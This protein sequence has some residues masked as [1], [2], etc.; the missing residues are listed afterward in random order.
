[1][2][3]CVCACLCCTVRHN[4]LSDLKNCNTSSF[5]LMFFAAAIR[6]TSTYLH[7]ISQCSPFFV[8]FFSAWPLSEPNYW[9][10]FIINANAGGLMIVCHGLILSWGIWF[11]L[12][13]C[14]DVAVWL[15][16]KRPKGQNLLLEKWYKWL[17]TTVVIG[18][19]VKV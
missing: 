10:T 7:A 1:M 4:C 19:D 6:T 5:R 9:G 14:F 13:L 16:M 18:E 17:V 12:L 2:C 15:R 3:V 8:F 11:A